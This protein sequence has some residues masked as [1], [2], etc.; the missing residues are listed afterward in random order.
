MT[1]LLPF[2]LVVVAA[3]IARRAGGR[4]G[5]DRASAWLDAPWMPVILGVLSALVIWWVWGSLSQVAVY[6]DEAAY[7]LQA[8]IFASGRWAAAARPLPAFFEQSAVLVTPVLAPKMAPGHAI[9]MVPGVWLGLPGLMPVVLGGV[10]GA[11]LYALARRLTNGWVAL[12]AWAVWVTAPGVLVWHAAYLSEATTG[13]LWLGGWWALL[14]W[15]DT[16]RRRWLLLLAACVGWGA[17]TRPLTML[18]YA[19]PVAPVVIWRVIRLRAWR[20]FGLAM[21]VGISILGILP[22]WSSRTTGD[23]RTTP[24]GLYTRMYMPWD[25]PGFGADS[26]PPL[27]PLPPDLEEV[28][29]RFEQIHAAYSVHSLPTAL[30]QRLHYIA[31]DMWPTWRH[32]LMLIAAIGLVGLSAEGVFA[33]ITAAV[34]VLAYLSYAYDPTWSVYYVEL[35]P[36]LAFLTALGCWKLVEWT[37]ALLDRQDSPLHAQRTAVPL[38]ILLV[39]LMGIAPALADVSR[40]Q[41]DHIRFTSYHRH[42]RTLIASIPTPRSIVFVR[43]APNHVGHFSLIRNTPDLARARTWVVYDRGAEDARLLALAPDRVAYLFDEAHHIIEPLPRSAVA[44]SAAKSA[45]STAGAPGRE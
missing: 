7:V 6:H 18:A 32:P 9:L 4:F 36:V 27:R 25:V 42:F 44:R 19:I 3:I 8:R 33:V 41:R 5:T 40:V 30:R 31:R 17:I 22:L 15:R 13:A 11:L 14:E 10:A 16:G 37:I 1:L 43:Y 28:H 38:A 21:A 29:G 34:L 20:D 23:W 45:S 12:L 35:L 39:L 2:A 26:T 24:L